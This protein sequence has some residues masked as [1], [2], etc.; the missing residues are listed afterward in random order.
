MESTQDTGR[1]GRPVHL[2]VLIHGL[3]GNPKNLAVPAEELQRLSAEASSEDAENVPQLVTYICSGFAGGHTWDGVDT[4]AWRA[5]QEVKREI[6]RIEEEQGLLVEHISFV[7]TK[8]THL[9]PLTVVDAIIDGLF[10]G[11]M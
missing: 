6:A 4:N 9:C 10:T 11:W 8:H 2:T 3:Y 1:R 7:S 5:L